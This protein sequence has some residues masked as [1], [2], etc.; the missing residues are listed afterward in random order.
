[1]TSDPAIDQVNVDIGK[2]M[3]LLIT[4]LGLTVKP[5][6]EETSRKATETMGSWGNKRNG[7]FRA[8]L[9]ITGIA[10]T[11]L[12]P[13]NFEICAQTLAA[14]PL[15]TPS[16][17]AFCILN[18]SESTSP[19]VK[20]LTAQPAMLMKGAGMKSILGAREF[21]GTNTSGVWLLPYF[22]EEAS[23]MERDYSGFLAR[24]YNVDLELARVYNL[25][26]ADSLVQTKYPRVMEVYIVHQLMQSATFGNVRSKHRPTAAKEGKIKDALAQQS[27]A[28]SGVR[29]T[30]DILTDA[31][32]CLGLL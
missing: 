21:I 12:L 7:A 18:A 13:R 20:A 31:L 5:I 14:N 27:A 16:L 30:Q 8:A 24:G 19:T 3:I 25:P 15:T 9:E 4:T 2:L 23:K 32:T 29:L 17:V 1:M 10:P 22:A 26:G 28:S 11:H 6:V